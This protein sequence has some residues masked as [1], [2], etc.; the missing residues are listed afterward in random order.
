MRLKCKQ[1]SNHS[2]IGL[3]QAGRGAQITFALGGFF[4][5]QVTPVSLI[6]PDVPVSAYFEPL[7]GT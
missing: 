4:C 5:Q 3:V 7:F 1:P 6:A 2:F